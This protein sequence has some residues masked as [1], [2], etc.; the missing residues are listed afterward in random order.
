[1]PLTSLTISQDLDS[2]LNGLR[3]DLEKCAGETTQAELWQ[4][5]VDS[6]H[7]LIEVMHHNSPEES[8][9]GKIEYGLGLYWLNNDLPKKHHW[10]LEILRAMGMPDSA[11]TREE[12]DAWLATI[13]NEGVIYGDGTLISTAQYAQ[14]DP[15]WVEA[16][17]YYVLLKLGF[18]HRY[19]FGTNPAET[20]LPANGPLKLAILGDWGTGKYQDGKLCQ[21]PALTV[22]D[23]AKGA[24][25]DVA[26]HLGDVYYAGIEGNE[27]EKFVD[28]WTLDAAQ[29]YTLNSN[30]EMYDGAHGYF[31]V[32]LDVVNSPFNLQNSTSY[33]SICYDKWLF[34]G[35]DSAYY[36][37][38]DMFMEGSINDEHQLGFLGKAGRLARENGQQII[39]LTHHCPLSTDGTS[40]TSLWSQVT[41]ALG[42]TPDFWYFGHMHNGVVYSSDAASGSTCFCRCVGH[43]AIPFGNGNW[44]KAQLGQAV[45]WYASKPLEGGGPNLANRVQNG[46]ALITLCPATKTLT[47]TFYNQD[48][49]VA[50][51][52]KHSQGDD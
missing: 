23:L 18:I 35:L 36:D 30:H 20:E 40:T 16:A 24:A 10:F 39:I 51:T 25:P 13:G 46:Y 52:K 15:G 34:I 5:L 48:G 38:S 7:L 1:M 2:R 29:N 14:L 33:F 11:I 28:L 12:L 43:G 26:I 49:S 31:K 50:F 8:A 41:A 42:A 21:T 22:R 17:I 47:E 37:D 32:A 4:Y 3:N 45:E 19:P 9:P 44:L 27:R 6:E